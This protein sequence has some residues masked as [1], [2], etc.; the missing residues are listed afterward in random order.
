MRLYFKLTFKG[1]RYAGVREVF[2]LNN[3]CSPGTEMSPLVLTFKLLL[4]FRLI[5]CDIFGNLIC[6]RTGFGVYICT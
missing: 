3:W 4:C 2:A 1:R 5:F 6:A